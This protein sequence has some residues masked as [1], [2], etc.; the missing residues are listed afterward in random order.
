MIRFRTQRLGRDI[1]AEVRGLEA[2]IDRHV[3]RLYAL[4]PAEIALVKSTA[5]K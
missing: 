1:A 2:D 4:T 5:A 3:Y